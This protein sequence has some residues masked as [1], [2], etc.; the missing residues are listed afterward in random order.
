MVKKRPEYLTK[1]QLQLLLSEINGQKQGAGVNQG[2]I[3]NEQLGI[4]DI[5]AYWDYDIPG[6]ELRPER[7]FWNKTSK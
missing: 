4:S 3:I 2:K 1:G 5:T 7:N 6:T